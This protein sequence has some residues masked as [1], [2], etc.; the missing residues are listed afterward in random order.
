MSQPI[1]HQT[2]APKRRT[3]FRVH[4]NYS[5]LSFYLFPRVLAYC[6]SD[7]ANPSG[8]SLLNQA[9]SFGHKVW[10]SDKLSNVLQR[11]GAFDVPHTSRRSK[12]TSLQ[13][14]TPSRP[15]QQQRSL[16]LQLDDER[17]N[18]TTERDPKQK[19]HDYKYFTKNSYFLLVEDL[20]NQLAPI[21]FQDYGPYKDVEDEK[22]KPPWPKL[23]CHNKSRNPFQPF[24][25]REKHRYEKSKKL[26]KEVAQNREWERERFIRAAKKRIE[27]ESQHQ[28]GGGD[29][30]RTVS[31]SHMSHRA[32]EE[33]V[34]DRDA[35]ASGYL[36]SGNNYVAASGNSVGI[37]STT[38]TTSATIRT[39]DSL[40]VSLRGGKEFIMSRKSYPPPVEGAM[41]PPAFI[42]EKSLRKT[43]STNS[44][45]LPK[46]EEG[47]K[48]GYCESCRQKFNDFDTVRSVFPD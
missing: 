12:A 22:A 21:I 41:G 19:R 24:D 37:T 25:D 34:L 2:T 23:F 47:S 5:A 17:V 7:S 11:C 33:A 42:P 3:P 43:K 27:Q 31:L 28:H 6:F 14:A 35:D 13:L 30:R 15:K 38:G 8:Q 4:S 48:P 18:G 32:A 40:P 36:A 1:L 46:R 29:L 39:R 44:V 26:D 16:K 10:T 9:L 20:R 45:R